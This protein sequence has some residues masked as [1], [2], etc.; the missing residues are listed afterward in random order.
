[1]VYTNSL[2]AV[3]RIWV[4]QEYM[5]KTTAVYDMLSNPK[6]LIIPHEKKRNSHIEPLGLYKDPTRTSK[7]PAL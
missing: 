4:Y 5:I 1:M 6:S 7:I 2:P 3:D